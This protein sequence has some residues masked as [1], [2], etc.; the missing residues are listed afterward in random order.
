M[1]VRKQK[2][3]LLLFCSIIF[4]GCTY[5]SETP[6]QT[7]TIQYKLDGRTVKHGDTMPI[8]LDLSED[9]HVDFTI[10]VELTANNQGDRLYAGINPIG[11]N[12]IKSGYPI[13]ENFLNMGLLIAENE[14]SKIDFNVGMNQQWTHESGALIIR[15]TFN[16]GVISYE[17]NWTQSEQIVGIQ[18]KINGFVYFGWLRIKFDKM[19][20]IV[21]L[22]DYAY[23]TAPNKF[24]KAGQVRN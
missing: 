12:L 8:I 16:N 15:N 24:I 14:Q 18:N 2:N 23:N 1:T 6:N 10:F 17:G 3:V 13:N 4:T 21:T 7:N 9:G 22:I 20:E 5:E 11:S 19:T